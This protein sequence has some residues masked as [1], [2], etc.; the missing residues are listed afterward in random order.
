MFFVIIYPLE[1][2]LFHVNVSDLMLTGLHLIF[3]S[4]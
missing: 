1:S 3:W 4:L 2:I